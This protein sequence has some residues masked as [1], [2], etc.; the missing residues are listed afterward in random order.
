MNEFEKLKTRI[1][2]EYNLTDVHAGCYI[3][4]YRDQYLCRNC[5][6]LDKCEEVHSAESDLEEK[7]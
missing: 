6:G 2:A 4:N 3:C 7:E 1:K 5:T